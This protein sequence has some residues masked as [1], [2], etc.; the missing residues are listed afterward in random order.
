M[1]YD[2]YVSMV[3][4]LISPHPLRASAERRVAVRGNFGTQ[5]QED[6]G[7]EAVTELFACPAEPTQSPSAL[8]LPHFADQSGQASAY[9]PAINPL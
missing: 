3:C 9:S 5:A 1:Q 4:H 6:P 7:V 2:V 8:G